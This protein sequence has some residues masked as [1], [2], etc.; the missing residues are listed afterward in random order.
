MELWRVLVNNPRYGNFKL[1][2]GD[3]AWYNSSM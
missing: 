3:D 2:Y 1:D